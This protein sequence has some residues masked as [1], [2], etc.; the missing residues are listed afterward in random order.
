MALLARQVLDAAVE[1][2]G[3]ADALAV[4]MEPH[5]HKRYGNSAIYAYTNQRAV[6]PGDVLLAAA[7]AAGISLDEKLGIGRQPTEVERQ[8]NELRAEMDELRGAVAGLQAQR[9]D[10]DGSPDPSESSAE[11]AELDRR[12]QRRRWATGAAAATPPTPTDTSRGSAGRDR[13]M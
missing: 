4:Q 5:L 7:L 11:G 1:S 8:M 10:D 13:R 3:T 9:M 2:V 6:P 12:A